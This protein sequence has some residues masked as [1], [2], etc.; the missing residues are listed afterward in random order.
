MGK[1]DKLEAKY[2]IVTPLFMA[3]ADKE[4][5]ELRQRC[6]VLLVPGD[7]FI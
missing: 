6:F 4:M 5:A 1:I 7:S 2:K 3:G